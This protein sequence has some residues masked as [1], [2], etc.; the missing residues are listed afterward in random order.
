MSKVCNAISYR[1]WQKLSKHP[2]LLL[3]LN[4][5][6]THNNDSND[7]VYVTLLCY[8]TVQAN[9]HIY[10]RITFPYFDVH[11][12]RLLQYLSTVFVFV[13]F[14]CIFSISEGHSGFYT[15]FVWSLVLIIYARAETFLLKSL[16]SCAQVCLHDHSK[17]LVFPSF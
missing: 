8:Q 17:S 9:T 2:I 16:F 14:K 6:G 10:V 7:T 4:Y 12:L 1:N 15:S 11:T 3:L 13:H 5:S